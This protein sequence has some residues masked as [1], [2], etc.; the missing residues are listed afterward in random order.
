MI[1]IEFLFA[2]RNIEGESF[3]RVTNLVIRAL[4]AVIVVF[5]LGSS[6]TQDFG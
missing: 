2:E 4:C 5:L 1:L 3:V 6:P